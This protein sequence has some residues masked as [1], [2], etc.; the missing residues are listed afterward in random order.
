MIAVNMNQTF[1]T[2]VDLSAA[3]REQLVAVLNQQLADTFDLYSQTKQAHWTSRGPS[4]LPF[5]SCST[6]SPRNWR[7]MWI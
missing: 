4:S 7:P 3:S 5:T 1:P 2:R 6:S